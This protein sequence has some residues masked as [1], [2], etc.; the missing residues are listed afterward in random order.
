MGRANR[1]RNG[2]GNRYPIVTMLRQIIPFSD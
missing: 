1:P 2:T